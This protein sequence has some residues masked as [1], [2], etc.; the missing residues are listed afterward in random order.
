M[1]HQAENAS[2]PTKVPGGTRVYAVGDIHGRIDLLDDLHRLIVSDS[3]NSPGQK[4]VLIHLGDYVDRGPHSFE[5]VDKLTNLSFDQF[6]ITNLKGNHEDFLLRFLEEDT[7]QSSILDVWILNGGEETLL[8]Y[9]VDIKIRAESTLEADDV[10]EKLSNAV[11]KSHMDFFRNLSIRRTIGDYL[12]VHAGVRPDIPLN[13]Q[14]N[15]DLL[16]I[17]DEFLSHTG[18]FEKVV[19]HGHTIFSIPENQDY[20][21]GIDTGAYYSNRL[22]CLVL[23]GDTRRFL[24]T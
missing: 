19:V 13:R 24:S 1:Q 17:R 21:I 15:G 18:P 11:P 22:T 8:S 6:E 2:V 4:L 10:R 16:W 12:F 7:G 5:V 20:R 3:R 9:G 23:E 14:R